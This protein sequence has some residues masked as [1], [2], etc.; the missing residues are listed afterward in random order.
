MHWL[1]VCDYEDC[2]K[3]DIVYDGEGYPILRVQQPNLTMT[4]HLH[5]G[6]TKAVHGLLNVL[7]NSEPICSSLSIFIDFFCTK[8]AMVSIR[9][10]NDFANLF[11]IGSINEVDLNQL[12]QC[13]EILGQGFVLECA[14]V[15][16]IVIGIAIMV[17]S[18]LVLVAVCHKHT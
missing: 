16:V 13:I 7:F 8:N 3:D 15:D 10:G 17:V 11:G 4:I 1:F 14:D 2:T 18:D 9:I 6:A 12:F 5:N